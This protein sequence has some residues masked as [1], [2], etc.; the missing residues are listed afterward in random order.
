M[1]S[2]CFRGDSIRSAARSKSFWT[3]QRTLR[4]SAIAHHRRYLN[5]KGG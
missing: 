4:S 2:F 1:K 3:G 5:I